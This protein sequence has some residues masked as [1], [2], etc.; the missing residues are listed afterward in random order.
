MSLKCKNCRAVYNGNI[1]P[2]SKFVKCPYCSCIIVVPSTGKCE[3]TEC[4]EFNLELFKVFLNKRGIT[5]F[6]TVSG[7]LRLGNEEVTVNKDGTVF[8]SKRLSSRVE[9]WLQKFML[10][11]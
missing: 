1:S 2:F 9:R 11:E 8:G 6:D 7:I 5:T 10:Q 3:V 4:K